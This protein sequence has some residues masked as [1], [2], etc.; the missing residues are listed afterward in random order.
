VPGRAGCWLT[1]P[2][3]DRFGLLIGRTLVNNLRIDRQPACHARKR[4]GHHNRAGSIAKT[5]GRTGQIE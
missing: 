2:L 1:A 4:H 5:A 3:P